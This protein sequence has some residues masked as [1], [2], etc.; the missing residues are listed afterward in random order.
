ML[1]RN[2][3]LQNANGSSD[4]AA[5]LTDPT[6][7]PAHVDDSLL[8]GVLRA[9]R[10]QGEPGLVTVRGIGCP[11]IANGSGRPVLCVHGLGHDAWDW[12][13][14]FVRCS[15]RAALLAFDLPG[16]GLADKPADNTVAYDMSLFVEAIL[17]AAAQS[18]EPP[19]VVGS[20][21]GGHI[22]LM[23]A[24]Q[25]PD[26]FSQL[27]LAAPGGVVDVPRPMQAIAHAYYSV[28]AI[29]ARSEDEIVGNS[30]KIFAR[31]GNRFDDVLAARKLAVHR[32]DRK[33]EF[34]IPFAGIVKDVFNHV[35]LDRIASIRIPTLVL[36]GSRD[37]VVPPD[38]CAAAARRM[39][40]RFVSFDGIGHCPHIEAADQ[41]ADVVM[42]FI[43]GN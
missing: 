18:P 42:S 41:F 39:N 22:A 17:A 31:S 24:L 26:A 4:S 12:T 38:A 16:F 21:L 2:I 20:S 1:L 13:P 23:A 8:A 28:D 35:V 25:K 40:A 9:G 15:N 30:R 3:P 6:K 27:V 37:V 14:F 5:A 29:C 11:T 36:S 43:E 10:P 33:R 7:I 19:V 32:S 34:A